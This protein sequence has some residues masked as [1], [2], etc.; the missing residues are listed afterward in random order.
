MNFETGSEFVDWLLRFVSL[1]VCASVGVSLIGGWFQLGRTYRARHALTGI[2]IRSGNTI[3]RFGV[4][5]EGGAVRFHVSEEGLGISVFPLVRILHPPLLVPW[6]E[7]RVSPSRFLLFRTVKLSF[8]RVRGVRVSIRPR[9]AT[10]IAAAAGLYWP[11]P[12]TQVLPTC[13]P[14][15][16]P[17]ECGH[18]PHSI[19]DHWN[20]EAG[21]GAVSRG[22][23]NGI[24][25]GA[26]ARQERGTSPSD[27][28]VTATPL[29][30]ADVDTGQHR[31]RR[32]AR[33]LLAS[34]IACALFVAM[35]A[36]IASF[37]V[38]PTDQQTFL[39]DRIEF[40]GEYLPG[41]G[42]SYVFCFRLPCGSHMTVSALHRTDKFEGEHP[43]P[44]GIWLEQKGARPT[45]LQPGTAVETKLVILLRHAKMRT[46]VSEQH[47]SPP[48]PARLEWLI[49]RIE[50]RESA[51][52]R[53]RLTNRS[54]RAAESLTVR[55]SHEP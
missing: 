45:Q 19:Y 20:E 10:R 13:P 55:H 33:A 3:L 31:R 35:A 6:S 5:Y 32:A 26:T 4:G 28:A 40:L 34:M 2:K 18:A 21:S 7:L 8:R 46:D 9:T 15:T 48:R 29:A 14:E 47:D 27:G 1:W 49:E 38:R 43:E 37:G 16:T 53:F 36:L 25:L 44:Q 23:A 52:R 50:D 51:W 12:S 54:R 42:V 24:V 41:D 11:D 17:D 30:N 39:A 22:D